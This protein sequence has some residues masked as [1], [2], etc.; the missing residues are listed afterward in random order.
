MYAIDRKSNEQTRILA[1]DNIQQLALNPDG[2]LFALVTGKMIKTYSVENKELKVLIEF[3]PEFKHT[4][5]TWSPDGSWLYFANCFG[6][7][8]VEL[9]R[10]S[11]DG[12]NEQLIDG[13]FP[14]I[15]HLTIHPD[16]KRLAFTVGEM[17]GNSSLW[18]MKN[19]LPQ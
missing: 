9:R 19:Y 15:K 4:T 10:I 3:K 18:V 5:M 12:K 14:H 1:E 11:K 2:N 16:G 8:K 7:E 17:S 6:E 13:S